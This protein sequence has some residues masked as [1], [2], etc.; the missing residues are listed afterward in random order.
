MAR[1]IAEKP[2]NIMK[3]MQ[4]PD[5]NKMELMLSAASRVLKNGS[6]VIVGT[7]APC[8]AAMLAQKSHAPD[9]TV[10][11]EAGGV[12]PQLPTMPISVGDSRTFHKGIMATSMDDIMSMLQRGAVDTC[13]I[14]GAQIDMYGNINSTVIGDYNHPKVRLPGSGGANDLAS[15]CW[16]SVCMTVHSSRRFVRKLDFVTTPGYL[17]GRGSREK[18]GLPPGSGPLSV[19]TDLCIMGFD[20]NSKRMVVSSIHQGVTKEEITRNTGFDLLWAEDI[21]ET[22]GPGKK[23]LDILRNEVDPMGYIISKPII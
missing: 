22:P 13:F 7:G 16:N 17:E 11:F 21:A 4:M 14:G 23:E 9:M 12:G 6:M 18:E 3:G 1:A 8:A 2:W 15:L 10:I 5:Y 19:I 20:A